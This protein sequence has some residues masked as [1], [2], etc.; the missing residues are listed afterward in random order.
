[1]AAA[2]GDRTAG[3]LWRAGHLAGEYTV[4][5]DGCMD[6]IW[7]GEH[8]L[9]VGA[10]TAPY[11]GHS[12]N[13]WSPIGFRF[14]P[15]VA[16]SVIG[17]AAQALTDSRIPAADLWPSARVA[18]WTER[19]WGSTDPTATLT[20]LC[21]EQAGRPPRVA[22]AATLLGA[23]RPI[24]DVA[25]RLGVTTRTLH[26]LSLRH[27]GYGPKT[28]ARI[29]RMRRALDL[30][31]GDDPTTVAYAAGY[32]DYAHMFR[33]LTELTGRSPVAFTANQESAQ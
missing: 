20:A 32:A 24:A 31:P 33:D 17:H 16:P 7:T 9:I 19:L 28:L 22:T 1:M 30:L 12:D 15:G 25:D 8:L 2:T 6:I 13:G 27:F 14:H 4:L 26:R 10:D 21:T 23:G 5:P 18:E 29:L 11:V 3:A